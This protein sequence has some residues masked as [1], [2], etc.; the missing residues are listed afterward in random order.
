MAGGFAEVGRLVAT[1]GL[2]TSPFMAGIGQAESSMKR[3]NASMMAVGRSMTRFVTLPMALAGGAAVK[4]Q[5]KFEESMTKII[6]LVGVS[7]TQVEKWNKEVLAM[8]QSTGRGPG[9]LAD[10]LYFVTSAGIRGAEAMEVLEMSAKAAAAGLGETKVVADLV[11]SAMNAY[12]KEN[13]SAAQ[14]TDILVASVREG[15]AEADELA[16]AMG[17]VLPIASEFGVTFDQV[18]AAFAGM[19]RTG[20]NARVAA[21]QLKAILSAMASPS[22]QSAKAMAEYGTNAETFRKTVREKGLIQA[23]LDLKTA[24]AGNESAM[25]E[26][27]PNIR[28]LMGT[29]DLLGANVDYNVKIFESL[30]NSGG[31]LAKAFAEVGGTTQQKLNVALATL[32]TTLIEVGNVLKPFVTKVL[33]GLNDYFLRLTG[34][35]STMAESQKRWTLGIMAATAALGPFLV[36]LS[37]VQALFLAN[38]IYLYVAAIAALVLATSK[39]LVTQQTANKVQRQAKKQREGIISNIRREEVAISNL[40]ASLKTATRGSQEWKTAQESINRTYS[41]YLPNLITE[42][43]SLNDIEIAQKRVTEARIADAKAIAYN[44]EATR[45]IEQYQQDYEATMG[46]FEDYIVSHS[47]ELLDEVGVSLSTFVSDVQNGL[48]ADLNEIGDVDFTRGAAKASGEAFRIYK[49]FFDAI[50]DPGDVPSYGDF[51]KEWVKIGKLKSAFDEEIAVAQ[52]KAAVF[53]KILADK[54]SIGVDVDVSSQIA[55]YDKQLKYIEAASNT[56][57]EQERLLTLIS[58]HEQKNVLLTGEEKEAHD[59]VLSA[60]R[61]ELK[62]H[63][64]IQSSLGVEARLT[65]KIEKLT[66][67]RKL[68]T[69]EGLKDNS[70]ALADAKLALK[71]LQLE[72]SGLSKIEMLRGKIALEKERGLYLDGE[73]VKNNRSLIKSLEQQMRY[74]SLVA[75]GASHLAML[76]NELQVIKEQTIGTDLLA[77]QLQAK[78]IK[79]KEEEIEKEKENIAQLNTHQRILSDI[80]KLEERLKTVSGDAYKDTQIE[81]ANKKILESQ[82]RVA[83][84]IMTDIQKTNE[85]IYQIEVARAVTTNP[86]IRAE[87][88]EQIDALTRQ[89]DLLQEIDDRETG[90]IG[91]DQFSGKWFTDLKERMG[92]L[93]KLREEGKVTGKVF[94]DMWG[95]MLGSMMEGVNHYVQIVG[96]IMTS[97]TEGMASLFEAQKQ[98]ELSAAGDNAKKREA[99][100]KKYYE[101][102]KKWSIAQA[103]INTA[104]AIGNALATSK[105][106]LP[107]GP[108][109]AAVAGAA[110]GIQVAAIK[111]ANFAQ[112]GVVYGETLARVGEYPGAR[113]NPEVIAP[114]DKL[115]GMLGGNNRVG[116]GT[117]QLVELRLKGRDAVAMVDMQRLLNNTY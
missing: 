21:T 69:K 99:I 70:K 54:F 18:G 61:D 72:T 1:L 8:A 62:I 86:A 106:F 63:N 97:F 93:K 53:Q 5:A 64:K 82:A 58:I 108:I 83:N 101:K 7:R 35:L 45:L 88:G 114:L 17:M 66:K 89:K 77:A 24:T 68:S 37:R 16:G 44:K 48:Q 78:A 56:M 75:E 67:E 9:E 49:K 98:R 26:I 71:V 46:K 27:L 113:S 39:W 102:Q 41:K 23:L 11:T 90:K 109:M 85:K 81:I 51:L 12:G 84:E 28:A 20:T 42:K 95:D 47:G 43:T 80:V 15:K 111:A 50:G 29:L 117:P 107:M 116:N 55:G 112:G 3:L 94:K 13:L 36:I 104:L 79:S 52:E 19:T 31:S 65:A 32:K 96:G 91:P 87:L 40:F 59:L 25:S 33:A 38:P 22:M 110:G 57:G 105:P 73:A 74:E 14:A 100:E 103:L 76:Q 30:K 92:A 4:T 10:A 2:N 60:L 34:S 115:K 6:G